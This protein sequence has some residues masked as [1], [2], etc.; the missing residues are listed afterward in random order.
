MLFQLFLGILGAVALT[1]SYYLLRV[2]TL[3]TIRES[4]W[5]YGQMRAIGLK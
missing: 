4:V 2:S 1:L 5:E 3:N